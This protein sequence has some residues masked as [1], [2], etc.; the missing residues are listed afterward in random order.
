MGHPWWA[1]TPRPVPAMWVVVSLT[2]SIVLVLLVNTPLQCQEW[3]H[4]GVTT[5]GE[6]IVLLP[7]SPV[8][9][10]RLSPSFTYS[11]PS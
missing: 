4:K 6:H 1:A 8:R 2:Q 7:C 3:P 11:S 9:P 10:T 5:F